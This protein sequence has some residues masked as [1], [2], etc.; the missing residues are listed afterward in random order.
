MRLVYGG[1]PLFAIVRL[2]LLGRLPEVK[3]AQLV[4]PDNPSSSIQDATSPLEAAK[5]AER[6]LEAEAE[7]VAGEDEGDW[8]DCSSDEEGS[9]NAA[10]EQRRLEEMLQAR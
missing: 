1:L 5:Q 6:S 9:A 2:Q 3:N 7:V 10:S 8:E 4:L